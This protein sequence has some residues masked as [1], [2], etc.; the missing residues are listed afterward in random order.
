MRDLFA[1]AK[2]LLWTLSR[3]RTT[4]AYLLMALKMLTELQLLWSIETITSVFDYLIQQASSERNYK[5]AFACD[6]CGSTLKRIEF[7]NLFRFHVKSA[8]SLS[9]ALI[10]TQI[11]F[12]NFSRTIYPSKKMAKTLFSVWS[13]VMWE[14]SVMKKQM[15]LQNQHSL[16][17]SLR[18]SFLPQTCILV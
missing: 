10:L 18:W 9:T 6:R 8:C 13:Q 3:V 7:C 16:C 2:F 12:K 17:L 11:S 1:I 14:S 4:I 5:C 15:Q